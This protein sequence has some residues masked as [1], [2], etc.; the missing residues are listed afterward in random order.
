M[1]SFFQIFRT[2]ELLLAFQAGLLR[3][4]LVFTLSIAVAQPQHVSRSPVGSDQA[5]TELKKMFVS[6]LDAYRAQDY[7][8]AQHQLE[9]LVVSSPN[10][11]EVNELL[12]LVYVAQQQDEKANRYLAKAIR[13][14]PDLVEARTAL[15]ANLLRLHRNKEAEAEF[16][17]VVQLEPGSFDANHNLGEFY[18]QTGDVAAAVP[19]LERAQK[20]KPEAYNNGYDL[21]LAYEQTGKLEE[22]RRQVEQLVSLQDS[23]E[24]HSLWGDIEEKSKNYLAAAAQYEE[25]VRMDPTESNLLNWGAELLLHQT[26]EPAVEVFKAGLARFPQSEHLQEGLGISL[27]GLGRFDDAARAFLR[28]ADLNPSDALPVTFLG[29]AYDNLSA[30]IADQVRA[31]L[32]SFVNND[33]RNAAVRYYYAMCLWKTNKQ[34]PEAELAAQVESL[35]RSAVA[36]DPDYSDAYLQ[37]G[38]LYANARKYKEAIAQY[39]Q[40]LR[41]RPDLASVHYRLG[42]AFARTGDSAH[43]QQEFAAFER[44]HQA[45]VDEATKG[46]EQIQQFVYTLRNPDSNSG[47]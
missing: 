8:E 15:A 37:L 29:K 20:A 3:A 13:L 11:F 22:A 16:K 40:A 24:L 4:V 23:A 47:K 42:Q 38:I 46:H 14:K 7:T 43:A 35:L 30:P 9:P 18:I 39:E 25:A 17:K 33:T 44:L 27:Y 6:A 10:S 45:E 19:S 41:V 5:S 34:E 26:F 36:L 21:A 2:P 32:E 28:A 31:R 12:G 1:C